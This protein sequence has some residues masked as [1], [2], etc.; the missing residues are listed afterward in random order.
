MRSIL[1]LIATIV[2]AGL[3]LAQPP[4]RQ[5]FQTRCAG[6]HGSDG[7]GG[8]HGPTI[9]ARIVRTPND[10]ELTAFL[11]T[12]VPLRGM[13]G[14]ANVPADE[15]KE[16]VAFLRTLA[17][18]QRRG[19][20]FFQV[21][22][23]VE[24]TSGKTLEGLV[25][26]ENAGALQLRTDD[27]RI[28]LL[29]K[30]G[31]KY[32]EVTSQSD[33][34][35]M[36]GQLSGNR[37][38]TA[39]QIDKS[40][41]SKLALQWVFPVPESGRLQGTPQVFDGIMYMPHTNTVIALDAGSGARLWSFSKPPTPG[42]TGNARSI[43]NNRSVTIAG[44]RLFMQLDNTHLLALNRFTGEV[45]WDTEMADFRQNYN[46][47][48]SLLAVENLVVAGTAGGEEGVRGF[49]A[50][51]D[52]KTGKEVWRFWTIPAPGEKGSETWDGPDIAH[53]GG[54]TWLT[55]SY[56]PENKTVYWTTGNAGPDFNGDN[57]KGDNLYTCSILA[58]DVNTGKLK[59]HFQATPHDE[60]DWDAVQPV[61]LVDAPWE[62]RPRKLLL[63]ANRNGF[64][65]VLDRQDGKL[66]LAKPLVKKLT[67]AKGIAPDGRP[68]MNPN[69]VP[70]TE[71]ARVCPAVEGA[72]NFFSTSYSPS[73]GLFYV[74]TLE[75]CTI[76]TKRQTPAWTAGRSYQG[77]GG[78]RDP[79]DKAQ[80][81]LRAFDI[82][83]GKV[84]WELPQQGKADSWTGT[85]ATAAGLVFF[86]DDSG[87]LSAADAATGKRLWT[88]PFT[89]TLHTSPMTYVFDNKQYVAIAVGSQVYSFALPAQQPQ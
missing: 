58:L 36:H 55:G 25:L 44:D 74:N 80:K 11:N 45:L 48:G 39:T 16:M 81:F 6:C 14:F 61:V 32:R 66:L 53:G 27:Q 56:D 62:G 68:I 2:S 84:V 63:Q 86:G 71:G 29:R 1:I 77:G 65:Y 54:P 22:T 59:W 17:T 26:G 89:E 85:L 5:S 76:Y 19:R 13:P 4:G 79:D 88:F 43:G 37:Y 69:Q 8:E 46:A 67:W 38:T 35:S 83:S 34:P 73:T 30:A 41:V 72:A 3:S 40:N 15:M 47:T 9:L 60:W 7:N 31:E 10:R 18:P 87:M 82:R 78:R 33:W 50:A 64:L 28:H 70:T 21:R 42:L 52:Q 51:Y 57:R 49:L 12:G 24:T 20:R 75:R 23:K